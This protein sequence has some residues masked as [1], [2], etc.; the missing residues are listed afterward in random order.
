MKRTSTFTMKEI[1]NQKNVTI[2]SKMKKA[3]LLTID[4]LHPMCN[5][6]EF[7]DIRDYLNI[8]IAYGHNVSVKKKGGYVFK[9][10]RTNVCE[11]Y[12]C[13][14]GLVHLYIRDD[15]VADTLAK[16]TKC[17]STVNEKWVITHRLEYTK[18]SF[19]DFILSDKLH[20]L[21]DTF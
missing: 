20:I 12:V 8:L 13:N 15:K 10:G 19:I 21:T 14:D 1:A 9:V 5:L 2:D 4:R 17:Y 3:E 16:T 11:L 7:L 18:D 6:D